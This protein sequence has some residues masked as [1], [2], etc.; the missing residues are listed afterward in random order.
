MIEL[1][2]LIAKIDDLPPMP[3]IAIKLIELAGDDDVDMGKVAAMISRDPAMTASLLKVCNSSFYGFSNKISSIQQA[4]S[5][6]GLKKIL[7]MA[8]MV[9]SSK[10]LAAKTKGYDLDEGDLWKHSFIT[11]TAAEKL[12]SKVR[13]RDAGMAFTAGLLHDIG[14]L[15]I[16]EYVGDKLAEI[17]EEAERDGM[18]FR[19]AETKVLGFSH[20]EAGAMLMKRWNFPEEMVDAILFHHDSDNARIDKDLA[21]IVQIADAITMIMGLGIGSDGLCYN[22]PDSALKGLGIEDERAIVEIMTCVSEKIA[23]SPDSLSPP[24]AN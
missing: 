23:A 10:Y 1:K 7:Q 12:A 2:E 14:K 16:H 15:I 19:K 24:R 22:V 3:D 5:L 11:A 9:L 13:Y 8:V 21:R 17:R 6:F 4:A 18:G 20:A